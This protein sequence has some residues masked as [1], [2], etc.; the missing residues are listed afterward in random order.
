LDQEMTRAHVAFLLPTGLLARAAVD[1]SAPPITLPLPPAPP[2]VEPPPVDPHRWD[3]VPDGTLVTG[4]I[5]TLVGA[6][7]VQQDG[8][9]CQHKNTFPECEWRRVGGEMLLHWADAS[10]FPGDRGWWIEPAPIWCFD[11]FFSG[12]AVATFNAT[13]VDFHNNTTNRWTQCN[14]M[15]GIV[16]G[17][18]CVQFDPRFPNQYTDM[19]LQGTDKWAPAGYE[20]QWTRH[21]GWSRWEYWVTPLTAKGVIPWGDPSMDVMID[22][23]ENGPQPPS[24]PLPFVPC[25]RPLAAEPPPIEEPD[26]MLLPNDEQMVNAMRRLHIEGYMGELMRAGGIFESPNPEASQ[27]RDERPT[28]QGVV[29]DD[30]SLSVWTGR[31]VTYFTQQTDDH[32]ERAIRAVLTDLHNSDEAR[33]KRGEQPVQPSAFRGPISAEGR[34]FVAPV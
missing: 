23:A 18:V 26:V 30:F 5:E 3:F 8:I 29:I 16:G 22:H 10:R 21:D 1:L 17:G 28:A 20:K 14:T 12:D 6:N 25:P 15:R 27:I 9:I 31:Y 24:A 19:S 2:V 33:Q 4:A 7:P 13:L 11:E 34:D 32:H